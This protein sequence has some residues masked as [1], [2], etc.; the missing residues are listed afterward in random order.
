MQ[1]NQKSEQQELLALMK[2][3]HDRANHGNMDAS[4]MVAWLTNEMKSQY[5]NKQSKAL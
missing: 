3:A 5:K 1:R 4:K 2:K